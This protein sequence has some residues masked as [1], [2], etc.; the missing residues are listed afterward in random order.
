VWANVIFFGKETLMKAA[1]SLKTLISALA[2]GLVF[3][4][5][6]AGQKTGE[7]VDDAAITTKVKTAFAKDPDVSAMKVHV[8]TDKG[9]VTLK[10]DVK[11][12]AERAKAAQL[13]RNIE[14]VKGVNNNLTVKN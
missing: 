5:A 9:F 7:A 12:P 11:S 1:T 13:A 3:G 14:G 6:G 8:E 2:L 10:G 4:C